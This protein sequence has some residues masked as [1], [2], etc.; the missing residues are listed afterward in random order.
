V[1]A[2]LLLAAPTAIAAQ[3]APGLTLRTLRFYRADAHQTAVRGFIG[4]PYAFLTPIGGTSPTLSYRI[5]VAVFDTAGLRLMDQAW[6]G[7]A[8]AEARDVPGA[9]GLEMIEFPV[10]A[11]QYRLQVTVQDSVTGDSIQASARFTGWDAMPEASDLVLASQMRVAGSD[12]T[13][14]RANEMRR[15]NTVVTGAG[16]VVLSPLADPG[17]DRS[18]LYYLLEAY[19]AGPDSGTMQVA[20]EDSTGRAMLR[21]SA[22]PIRLAAGGGILRGQ[23]DLAGLPEGRYRLHATIQIDGRAVERTAPFR[24]GSFQTALAQSQQRHE[25]ALISDS[26]YFGAMDEDQLNEAYAPLDYV[27]TSKDNLGVWKKGL[28]VQAKRNFLIQFWQQRDPSPGTPKNEAREAFY[29]LIAEANRQFAEREAN[30]RPG[31]RTDRGRIFIKNGPPAEKMQ[32]QNIGLAQPY[33]VW[34]YAAGKDRWYI[35]VDRT[36]FGGY[37]LVATNDLREPSQPGWQTQLGGDV[38]ND[39]GHFLNIDFVQQAL[40][41]NQTF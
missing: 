14:P 15:G 32:R 24:M 7:H 39:I 29:N 20:V 28:T 3:V 34:R 17:N 4:I 10:A 33:E 2:A 1:A 31:W 35:F 11:G 16:E 23:L 5:D 36:S 30:A 25:Q 37:Q 22:T 26:G 27:A 19:S 38:L 9:S 6:R 40:R 12:D 18:K 8:P 13:I 21:T 41:N